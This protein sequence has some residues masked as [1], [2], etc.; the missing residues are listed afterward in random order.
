MEIE[1]KLFG[2]LAHYMP[3]GSNRFSFK[4]RFEEGF[5]IK[6]LLDELSLPGDMNI[7]VIVNGRSADGSYMLKDGDEVSLFSPAA[8]G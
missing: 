7:F 6:H 1:V 4:K 3:D 5:T 8:G 2:N